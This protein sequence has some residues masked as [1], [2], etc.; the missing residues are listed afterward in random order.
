MTGLKPQT[1]W[2]NGSGYG[3][4][5]KF[6]EDIVKYGWDGFEHEII[7]DNLTKPEAQEKEIELIKEYKTYDIQYGYNKNCKTLREYKYYIPKEREKLI[8]CIELNLTFKTSLAA[9]RATGIDNSSILKACKGIRQ[10]AGKHPDT[11]E[12]LHWEFVN[13]QEKKIC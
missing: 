11:R 2:C 13:V 8:H 7:Y 12:K 10:S 6:Y 5:P 3:N 1:R 4:Q 9:A